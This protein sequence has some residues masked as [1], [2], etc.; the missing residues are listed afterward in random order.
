MNE[1]EFQSGTQ[2]TA[3]RL[4]DSAQDV[5]SRAGDYMQKG[6][7]RASDAAQDL[8]DEARNRVVRLT[9]RPL[10]SWTSDVRS[11]VRDHPLQALAIT[12][13]IGYILGK[14]MQRD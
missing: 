2:A 1:R 11:L 9:G 5:A 3:R 7:S 12:I 13:G 8:A 10:D 4:A 14:L 6:M